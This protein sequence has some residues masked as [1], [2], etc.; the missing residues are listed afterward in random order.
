MAIPYD[1]YR[2]LQIVSYKTNK[3]LNFLLKFCA[4]CGSDPLLVKNS[5]PR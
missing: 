3:I 2:F 1:F 4:F 5:L